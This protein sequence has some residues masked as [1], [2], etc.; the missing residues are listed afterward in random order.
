MIQKLLNFGF[1][2]SDTGRISIIE[3]PYFGIIATSLNGLHITFFAI[4]FFGTIRRKCGLNFHAAICACA[5]K[6]IW[7]IACEK[8]LAM[9]A[10]KAFSRGWN[11]YFFIKN[12]FMTCEAE[13][14]AAFF[15]KIFEG[16]LRLRIG[17]FGGRF[18]KH[19]IVV[20]FITFFNRLLAN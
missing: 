2:T 18:F 7:E 19:G 8:T 17:F 14:L 13:G 9:P 12:K 11:V 10:E 4:D 6:K 16:R 5:I 15:A 3:R 20:P 1:L